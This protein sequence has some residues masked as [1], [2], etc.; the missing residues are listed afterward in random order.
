MTTKGSSA[1]RVLVTGD[2]AL[3]RTA[4]A[5]LISAEAGMEVCGECGNETAALA[6]AVRAGPDVVVM[7]LEG[8]ARPDD[9]GQLVAQLRPRPV[10]VL[11]THERSEPLAQ[12]LAQGALGV[13]VKSRP[14][15]VLMRA[16]RA[17]VAG[18]TW[19][20]PSVLLRMFGAPPP[21]RDTEQKLT[22]RER[23]IIEL[24]G[25]GLKNRKIGERLF[26]SETT[27]RHHLTSIFS[28]LSVSSR[29]ELVRY[30]HR[31]YLGGTTGTF[32]PGPGQ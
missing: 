11:T 27:V 4:I 31:G 2:Y 13:V 1:T 26:I 19:I 17:V 30:A 28:K 15:D 21:K 32:V 12:A 10:V 23:Q 14:A 16:V 8:H 7:D 22:R 6:E 25:L 5:G 29:L 3:M 20:E 24:V 18:E 9:V